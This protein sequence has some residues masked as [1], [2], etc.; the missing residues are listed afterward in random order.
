[1]KTAKQTPA[2]RPVVIA[3]ENKGFAALVEEIAALE[4]QHQERITAFLQGYIVAATVG[5]GH[6]ATA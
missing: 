4:P 1:M 6:K 2:E 3:E 5:T